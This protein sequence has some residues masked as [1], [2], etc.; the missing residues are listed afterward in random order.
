MNLRGR[1]PSRPPS[2]EFKIVAGRLYNRNHCIWSDFGSLV[3]YLQ[4][5]Q[6]AGYKSPYDIISHYADARKQS[7]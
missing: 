4:H 2:L 1:L 7:I 3:Q 5:W 6:R